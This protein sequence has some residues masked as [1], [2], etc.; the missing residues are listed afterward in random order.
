MTRPRKRV[1][2]KGEKRKGG[3]DHEEDLYLIK[4]TDTS[5]ATSTETYEALDG[6]NGSNGDK[7]GSWWA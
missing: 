6:N 2:E 7:E 3:T 4:A 1:L 5:E